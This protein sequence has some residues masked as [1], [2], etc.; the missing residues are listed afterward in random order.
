VKVNDLKIA[1]LALGIVAA[2]VA[3]SSDTSVP[4]AANADPAKA[5]GIELSPQQRMDAIQN[6][7]TMSPEEKA[8]KLKRLQNSMKPAATP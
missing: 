4:Q 6:S 2:G 8:R 5:A 1:I 3:C 7:T